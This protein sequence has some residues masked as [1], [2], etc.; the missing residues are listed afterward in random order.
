MAT[1]NTVEELK[2]ELTVKELKQEPGIIRRAML[3]GVDLAVT[4][5]SKPLAKIVSFQRW[6]ATMTELEELR[7]VVAA[8]GLSATSQEASAA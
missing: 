2:R 5:H 8:A 3:A 4:F 6:T 7:R 1:S